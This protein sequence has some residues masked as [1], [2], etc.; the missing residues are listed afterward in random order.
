MV[1]ISVVV[2]ARK[3]SGINLPLVLDD[4]FYA[5][6]YSSKT[7]FKQ[8]IKTILGIFRKYN[9][10]MPLQLILFSHDELVF[11]S[12]LDAFAEFETLK[13]VLPSNPILDAQWMNPIEHRT[14]FARLFSSKDVEETPTESEFGKYWDLTYKI[15]THV[16]QLL[17]ENENV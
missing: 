5:S 15:P 3:N 17:N 16:D 14:I 7:T 8:F 13:A 9:S 1:S 11:D 6:D 12:A 10:E 2:A 4:V